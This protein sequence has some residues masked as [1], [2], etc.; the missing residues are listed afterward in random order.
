[1][2]ADGRYWIDD[3]HE[4]QNRRMEWEDLSALNSGGADLFSF[5]LILHCFESFAG[6]N[7]VRI[8]QIVD[9]GKTIG[10]LPLILCNKRGVRTLQNLTNDHWTHGEPLMLRG[11]EAKF[12]RLVGRE[13]FET[14]RDWDMLRF[15][16]SYIY[17]DGGKGFAQNVLAEGRRKGMTVADRTYGTRMTRSFEEY[18]EEDLSKNTRKVLR[19][20][21]HKMDKYGGFGFHCYAGEEALG[22]WENFLSL[23]DSGWK[24]NKG[25]SIKMSGPQTLKFYDGLTRI[26]AKNGQLHLFFLT[27]NGEEAAG[28]F[29]Y[30]EKNILH[31]AKSG[32]ATKFA[33]YSPSNVLMFKIIEHIFEN[34]RDIEIVHLFPWDYGYKHRFANMDAHY[35]NTVVFNETTRG[36]FMRI[37]FAEKEKLKKSKWY[38]KIRGIPTADKVHKLKPEMEKAVG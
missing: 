38:Q 32:Y 18:L 29:S 8:L 19:K 11:H 22:K 14:K 20:Y 4:F 2:L 3:L 34:R 25:A 15:N 5:D 31:C 17:E 28:Q 1:M 16:Y 12:A 13:L 6:P 23:E 10:F 36:K 30:V 33:E 7:Q 35:E 37:L 21:L 24:K 27:I 9:G 26:L